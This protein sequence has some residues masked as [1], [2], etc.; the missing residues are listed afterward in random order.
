MEGMSSYNNTQLTSIEQ[1][2]TWSMSDIIDLFGREIDFDEQ[3][4]HVQNRI[5]KIMNMKIRF[6]Q[7]EAEIRNFG[8]VMFAT[9][10]DDREAIS[11]MNEEY[12]RLQTKLDILM[13]EIKLKIASLDDPEDSG[14]DSHPF[15]HI[16]PNNAF[17]AHPSDTKEWTQGL[18]KAHDRFETALDH[19]LMFKTDHPEMA[20]NMDLDRAIELIDTGLSPIVKMRLEIEEYEPLF[21]EDPFEE[22]PFE[23]RFNDAG[24]D[25][26][27]YHSDKSGTSFREWW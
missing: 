20:S 27:Y 17:G 4:T 7:L 21:K 12:I 14:S 8:P 25:W 18:L 1:A 10:G 15:A 6:L 16:Y 23:D 13:E 19:L 11:N 3:P 24:E 22:D 26:G 2:K 9:S 5:L